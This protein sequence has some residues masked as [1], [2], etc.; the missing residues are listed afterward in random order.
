MNQINYQKILE[1]IKPD[2][3]EQ[4]EVKKNIELVSK[5]IIEQAKKLEYKIKVTPGGS[6][7]KGTYLKNNYDIDIFV[8]FKTMGNYSDLLEKILLEIS[9]KLN[10]LVERVHGSRD[11]F[12]FQYGKFFFEIVPV[13]Y[14]TEIKDVENVTDMSPLH[15]EWIKQHLNNLEDDIRLA[16][17][18]CKASG[19][20]GAE[21]YIKGL[22]GH[23]LDIL[24][25]YYGGFEKFIKAVSNWQ[26]HEIID[27]EKKHEDVFKELNHSK[28]ESPLIVIDPINPERNA[29]AAVS[30]EKFNLLIKTAKKFIEKPAE[31]FFKI[32][33]FSFEKL[34][35]KLNE[36]EILFFI[37]IKPLEGKK[38]IVATK[39][40]K[41][42]EF[43][44][45]HAQ[46][47]E[48][49][50]TKSE[51]HFNEDESCISLF[52]KNE[53]LSEEI[54]HEGPPTKNT[55]A[56][57]KFLEKHPENTYEKNGRIYIK[58]ERK[59]REPIKYI[60]YLLS[61]PYTQERVK[62]YKIELHT[63]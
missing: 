49:E 34:F 28:L 63:K 38:D 15:V 2:L 29:A 11:Y 37:K 17:Q 50:V 3:T 41:V 31:D 55:E 23:V 52:I 16:K 5:L 51:W 18:F 19:V 9:S 6:T 44:K 21:S 27:P 62:N 58:I 56:V 4:E 48:F 54:E 22:S 25:I 12:Q 36:N 10:V 24:I 43:L 7:S 13:K 47:K 35:D 1:E 59:F 60:Q 26:G 46:L 39:I 42:F 53:I 32:K 45:T 30:E 14:V 33:P 20:Y 57:K 8:R 61:E 40:L